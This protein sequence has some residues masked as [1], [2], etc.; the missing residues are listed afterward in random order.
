MKWE[1]TTYVWN[2][3]YIHG[4]YEEL[5]NDLNELGQEGWEIID[6]VPLEFKGN[7]EGVTEKT[8]EVVYLLKRERN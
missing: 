8:D 1:Y 3:A 6:S 5:V 4:K 7:D 2:S